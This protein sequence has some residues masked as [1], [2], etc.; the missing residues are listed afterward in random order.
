MKKITYLMV[1]ALMTVSCSLVVSDP[2]EKTLHELMISV[3][4]PEGY[5]SLMHEG[6]IAK[7]EDINLGNRYECALDAEG[8]ATI[9][10]PVGLY[11]V[12]VSDRIDKDIFN[13]TI[14]RFSFSS[15]VEMLG[16]D[17][18]HTKAG[19]IVIKEIYC[20]G[21]RKDPEEGTYNLDKYVILHNNDVEV[22]YLDSLCFGYMYPYNANATNPFTEKD[23]EGKIVYKDYVAIADAVWQFPGDGHAFPLQPGEDAVLCVNGAIDHAAKYP[24]SVNLNKSEYFVTY[25][26]NYFPNQNY[27]PVP[28]KNIQDDHI[29]NC[30]IK[31][32][33]GNLNA[34]AM[35]QTSPAVVI[36]RAKGVSIEEFITT[37]T[38]VIPIPG[39]T[40]GAKVLACPLDWVL[41]AVEV[42]NGS[43]SANVKRL[44]DVLDAGQ[45]TQSNTFLG[46]TL[47]RRVDEELT[48]NSG[49]EVLMDT[50]NSSNDM[51]ESEKQ[52]LHE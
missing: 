20:G 17:L 27:H 14:D 5:E 13:A 24:L 2:Y 12:S 38:G 23:G 49:Y 8:K 15:A 34:L 7:I 33:A 28:G 22:Q 47:M 44:Q 21:C 43:S 46:H 41:D 40:N 6:V 51:Y 18:K 10:L 25:N 11:R 32:G 35:S 4:F 30:L 36:Y 26:P 29:L 31:T 52:S 19:S 39:A 45:V 50:N 3:V 48:A 1:A 9:S 37:E 42:F 16:L